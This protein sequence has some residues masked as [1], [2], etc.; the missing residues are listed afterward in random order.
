[1]KGSIGIGTLIVFIAM[2]LV[3]AVAASVLI[4]TSSYLQQKAMLT[5][6]TTTEEVSTGLK[7]V[8]VY[9]AIDQ[10]K[11]AIIKLAIVI[12]P[13]AGSAPLDLKATKLMLS[14]STVQA[15]LRYDEDCYNNSIEYR[16]IFDDNY[17]VWPLSGDPTKLSCAANATI[18]SFGIIVLQDSDGSVRRDSPIIN[19]GDRVALTV[20]TSGLFNGIGPRTHVT[21]FVRPEFGAPGV[22]DFV[23][24]VLYT[25][26]RMQLQ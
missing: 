2:V 16:D 8:A 7:V 24:P 17:N 11:N 5:G 12:E 9:G 10:I 15:E 18:T 19:R 25:E 1:M 26:T 6:R 21:G 14:N 4:Q 13:N 20:N 23:T 3:A 22:I